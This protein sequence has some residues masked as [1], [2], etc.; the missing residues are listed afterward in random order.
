MLE[1]KISTRQTREE[2]IRKG[3][4]IP[5]QGLSQ[6]SHLLLHVLIKQ[7]YLLVCFVCCDSGLVEYI[8]VC[9]KST[10]SCLPD[11]NICSENLNG[12]ATSSVTSE[13]V[14]VH[15]ESPETT[16]QEQEKEKEP[17]PV[18]TKDKAGKDNTFHL[19]FSHT[20]CYSWHDVFF[21]TSD[22][23][24]F[25]CSKSHSNRRAKVL[26]TTM[27]VMKQLCFNKLGIVQDVVQLMPVDDLQTFYI[28][29]SPWPN[30]M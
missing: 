8:Y 21:F 9:C 28:G 11:E 15:I 19:C 4:L 1:R 30:T 24:E 7:K 22:V 5:D 25:F 27:S 13:E 3:V 29:P 16:N 23:L 12:H 6:A 17:G 10:I 2:L 14:K 26:K 18:G 20:R